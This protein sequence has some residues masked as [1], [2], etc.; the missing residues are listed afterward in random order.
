MLKG[1]RLPITFC[2]AG[3]AFLGVG[4]FVG[5]VLLVAGVTLA[6]RILKRWRQVTFLTFH[7]GMF[8]H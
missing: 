6:R 2:V 8:Y 4:S 7:R 5:I 3:F 1:D